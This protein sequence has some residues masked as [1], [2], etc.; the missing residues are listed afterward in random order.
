MNDLL[1]QVAQHEKCLEILAAI[2]MEQ[3]RRDRVIRDI[4]TWVRFP[5]LTELTHKWLKESA[6][7]DRVI[8][9]LETRYRKEVGKL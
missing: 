3:W 2:R 4:N 5:A 6:L 1:K 9:Y 8:S 7:K